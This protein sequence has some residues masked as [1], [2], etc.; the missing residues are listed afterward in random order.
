MRSLIAVS[1][2]GLAL[3]AVG[4]GGGSL[5]G[6]NPP[7]QPKVLSVSVNV[8]P[9]S[10]QAGATAQ[11]TCTVTMSDGT[12]NNNCGSFASDNTSVA[13]VDA[14][15]GAIKGVVAGTAHITATANADTQVSGSAT[16]TVT[17]ATP[18]ITSVTTLGKNWI[19]CPDSCDK[20]T[21]SFTMTGTGF[22]STDQIGTGGYWPTIT[23]TSVSADGTSMSF[24]VTF[25]AAQTP[26]TWI[27]FQD[28][29]TDGTAASNTVAFAYLPPYNSAAFGPNGEVVQVWQLNTYPWQFTNNSWSVAEKFAQTGGPST[30]Y[31]GS[32]YFISGPDTYNLDG[33]LATGATIPLFGI[34]DNDVAGNLAC[35]AQPGTNGIALFT[36]GVANEQSVPVPTGTMSYNCRVFTLNGTPYV[37]S[38]SVD[39]TP[40]LWLTNAGGTGIG[41]TGLQGVTAWSQYTSANAGWWLSVIKSGTYTGRVAFLSAYDDLLLIYDASTP[42]LPIVKSIPLAKVCPLPTGLTDIDANGEFLVACLNPAAQDTSFVAFDASGNP[43]AVTSATTTAFPDGFIA[44]GTDIYVVQGAN[45]PVAIP[46][47]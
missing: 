9:A 4:C 5:G 35:V 1:F 10:I 29:P 24:S 20:G 39:G 11:A 22:A 12:T 42:T 45:P 46:L 6:T 7:P 21:V 17:R 19:G 26:G 32:T 38:S 23:P 31:N 27:D 33:S 16:L 15:T 30:V 44:N 25:G 36:P 40:S 18:T 41:S 14:S 37:V 28:V 8:T 2:F 3:A 43:V 47:Q 34:S 13:T